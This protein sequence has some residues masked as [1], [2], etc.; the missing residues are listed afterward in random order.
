MATIKR[1]TEKNMPK[2]TT[3][4]SKKRVQFRLDAPGA[5]SVTLAGSFN[6]WDR[7]EKPM[8][9]D[10]MGMWKIQMTLAPGAYEYRFVVDG[11]WQDDPACQDRCANPFGTENCLAK[12]M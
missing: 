5:K 8:K 10:E 1:N 12:V 11:E 7:T 9:R 3:S 4:P 6:G 2:K